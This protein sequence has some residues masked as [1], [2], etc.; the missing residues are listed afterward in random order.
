MVLLLYIPPSPHLREFNPFAISDNAL[1][2][3]AIS[4]R[5]ELARV[6]IKN[7]KGPIT[8]GTPH[9]LVAALRFS[10]GCYGGARHRSQ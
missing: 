5:D 2:F 4:E 7:E 3:E 9:L 6:S 10:K 1:S 8:V